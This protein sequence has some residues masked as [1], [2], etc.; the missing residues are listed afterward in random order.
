MKERVAA[1]GRCS[2]VI[3]ADLIIRNIEIHCYRKTPLGFKYLQ[4]T[5]S[6]HI[7]PLNVLLT[8]HKPS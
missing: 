1:D 6:K 8:K 2:Q 4:N 7:M 5:I 3:G